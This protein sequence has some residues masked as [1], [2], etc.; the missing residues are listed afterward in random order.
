MT[1]SQEQVRLRSAIAA[2]TYKVAATAP[3]ANDDRNQRHIQGS[4]W[5]NTT[6]GDEYVCVSNEPTA[7]VWKNTTSG[8]GSGIVVMTVAPT[9]NDDSGDGYTIGQLWVNT[10]TDIVY[11]V[12]DVTVGAAIWK[13]LSSSP[14]SMPPAV[15]TTTAPTINDDS[16]D[17]YAIG[18]MWINTVT[19]IVYTATDVTVGAAVWK[20]LSSSTGSIAASAVTAV[21]AVNNAGTNVQ[22]QLDNINGAIANVFFMGRLLSLATFPV[23][24]AGTYTTVFSV[25][26][27]TSIHTYNTLAF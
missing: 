15:V 4:R 5:I 6:T 21:P 14:A 1:L 22:A 20:D 19:D 26:K 13:D 7:A 17:G 11:M 10:V 16:G 2:A 12:T 23:L 24:A 9:I 18:Q 3:T 27:M 25:P 8:G